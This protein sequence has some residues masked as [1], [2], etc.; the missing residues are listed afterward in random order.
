MSN[1]NQRTKRIIAKIVTGFCMALMFIYAAT[2]IFPIIWMLINSLKD[3]ID[4]YLTSSFS[5]PTNIRWENFSETLKAMSYIVETSRGKVEFTIIWQ[6]YYSLLYAIGTGIYSV[7]TITVT[8]Y[9]IG[10]YKFWL[11]KTL[12]AIGLAVMLL[13]AVSDGGAGLLMKKAF[14]IYDNMLMLILTSGTCVFTGQF[15]F[16]MEAHFRAMDKDYSEAAS[17]DG[18]NEWVIM[19]QIML[20]LTLPLM[21]TVFVLAFIAAWNNYA[22]FLYYLPSYANLSLGIYQFQATAPFKGYSTPHILAGFLIIAIPI[23]VLYVCSQKVI[24]QNL[25]IGGLKG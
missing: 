19:T 25:T 7:I 5:L 16:I 20:P 15:F 17:I 22:V 2:L 23:V 11:T 1:K 3:P 21:F 9:A 14:G 6:L 12:Y 8:A 18:A 24:T 4:Y 10:R 13:P